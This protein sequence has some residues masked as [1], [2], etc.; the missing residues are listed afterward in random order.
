M[1]WSRNKTV[2]L[3]LTKPISVSVTG[4]TT[5]MIQTMAADQ[6]PIDIG[7]AIKLATLMIIVTQGALL[8][9]GYSV[10]VGNYDFYGIDINELDISKP[11][12]LLYGYIFALSTIFKAG[13]IPYAGTA[14]LL[15]L[16]LLISAMFVFALANKAKVS[17]RT[18]VLF[19][20]LIPLIFICITP[21]KGIS[22][23]IDIGQEEINKFTGN[24]QIGTYKTE[25]RVTAADNRTLVGQLILA[26]SQFTF[27]L[28][29]N[30]AKKGC[31]PVLTVYK[32]NNSDNKILRQTV[33]TLQ[34]E[35]S[36]PAQT[37]C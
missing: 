10:L 4:Q 33:L 17:T 16:C 37:G 29:K 21:A 12:L 11:T 13:G 24:N 3:E 23:G 2:R 6:P 8:I 28:T 30:E 20:L 36:H 1:F 7:L 9:Y 34:T 25:Q 19:S 15:M 26:D 14:S 31:I 18:G 32:L 35:D 22:L 27:L 5:P